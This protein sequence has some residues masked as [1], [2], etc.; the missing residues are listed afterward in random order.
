MFDIIVFCLIFWFEYVYLL[1]VLNGMIMWVLY[2]MLYFIGGFYVFFVFMYYFKCYK[3][4]WWE[5]Y[6]YIILVVFIGGVVFLGIII[7]F[8][9]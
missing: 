8:V 1:L 5:K 4:V 3:I 7:F 9:V 6:N 2:N